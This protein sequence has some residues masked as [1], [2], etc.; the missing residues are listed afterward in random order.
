MFIEPSVLSDVYRSEINIMFS[1]TNICKNDPVRFPEV[2]QEFW[3]MFLPTQQLLHISHSGL[4]VSLLQLRLSPV[5]V[6]IQHK[7]GVN[8]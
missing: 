1:F 7:R 5:C 4:P 3:I 8:V 2:Q 6:E